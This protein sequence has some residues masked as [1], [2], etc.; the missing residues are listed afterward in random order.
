VRD[1]AEGTQ[2]LKMVGALQVLLPSLA[3][4]LLQAGNVITYYY[5]CYYYHHFIA[6]VL[7]SIPSSS[8]GQSINSVQFMQSPPRT[9]QDKTRQDKT[10]QDKTCT[11]KGTTHRIIIIIIISDIPTKYLLT[12]LLRYLLGTYLGAHQHSFPPIPPILSSSITVIN[13]DNTLAFMFFHALY[14]L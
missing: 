13:I 2:K 12:Y 14:F 10:R 9:R 5:C 11:L 6:G 4:I 8:V 1:E 3:S 7:N